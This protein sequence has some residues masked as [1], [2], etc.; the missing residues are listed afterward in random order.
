MKKC[1]IIIHQGFGDL[2]NSIGLINY[3]STKYDYVTVFALDD[4]RKIII[5]AIYINNHKITSEIPILINYNESSHPNTCIICMCNGNINN[6]PRYN[7]LQCKFINYDYYKNADI[8]KIGSF[9]N[10]EQWENFRSKQ[11]SFA[12]SFY[13]YNNINPE[14]RI[15]NFELFNDKTIETNLY[16]DF[17]TEYGNNYIL[18][19]EDN[20]RNLLIDKSKIINK[21]IP[22]INLDNKSKIFVD[23]TTIIKNAKEIHLIDS[24][25]SVFIYLLSKN[26]ITNIP[27]LLNETYFKNNGRDTGIYKNP[28]FNNWT[29]Y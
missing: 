8:I 15:N 14:I 2:F 28:S 9:N 25:W 19:H 20:S 24:S 17:I 26:I 6:C 29:F 18:I 21:N 3:Y 13:L 22:I 10:Y 5:D 4:A 12:H 7:N 1:Y 27:V 23:Y 11:L 16:N